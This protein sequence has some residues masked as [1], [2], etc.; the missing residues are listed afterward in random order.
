MIKLNLSATKDEEIKVKNYLENNASETLANKINNGVRIV[1]DGKA[2]ISKKTLETFLKYACEEAGK[3]AEKGA[4]GIYIDDPTVFGW[5]IHYFEED[6]I[7]G[8]LYNEDGTEHK[9]VIKSAA[10]VKT[11]PVEVTTPKPK[12]M[13]LFD[14]M[15]A[16]AEE[17]PVE[18]VKASGKTKYSAPDE[19]GVVYEISSKPEEQGSD[20]YDLSDF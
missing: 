14:L 5:A 10:P 12:N 17:I 13:T 7:E 4:K 2:L 1:K 8:I 15:D 18:P 19:D 9:P 16:K 20:I 11:K 6:S 3:K